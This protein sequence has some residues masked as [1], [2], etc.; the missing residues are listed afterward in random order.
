MSSDHALRFCQEDIVVSSP[1]VA[2]FGANRPCKVALAGFGTVGQSVARILCSRFAQ[3]FCLTHVFNRRIEQKKTDWVPNHVHWTDRFEHV[4]NSD[5]DVVLELVGGLDPAGEW[6]SRALAVGKSVVTA[7]KQ[8]IARRGPELMQLARENGAHL[9][10][11]ASVAGGI[12]VLQGLQDGLAGDRILK[13]RGIL[14]GTC[15]Y[16][17]T[18][19]ERSQATFSDALEQAQAMGFAEADASDDIDGFDARAKLTI[20]SRTAF[21]IN[22]AIDQVFARSIREVEQVDLSHAHDLGCTIRQ[23]SRAELDGETLY[24]GVQP[25]LVPEASPLARVSGSQNVVVSTGEFGGETIFSGR[26]AGGD[27]TAVAVVSDLLWIAR[28]NGLNAETP[29]AKTPVKD[30][31]GDFTTAHYV[32]FRVNDRPGI[33]ASLANIFAKYTINI[34]AVLQRPGYSKSSLPFVITLEPCSAAT[35]SEAMAEI[36]QLDFHVHPPL[37]LP[38]LT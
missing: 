9:L 21:G 14:N 1:E 27:P 31:S 7:N 2:Q 18:E 13:I 8:L 11:G 20:L 5:A 38:I 24:A 12:P 29:S 32:R 33:I 3:Q 10:Y 37:D 17:L 34:D 30:V 22:V 28:Q 35:M 36:R 16:I 6:V 25:A 19:M 15:N 4:L 26:G 23:I